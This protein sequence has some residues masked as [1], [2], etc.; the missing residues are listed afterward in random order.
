MEALDLFFMGVGF[1]TTKEFEDYDERAFGTWKVFQHV[2]SVSGS[3]ELVE[4][5]TELTTENCFAYI[6]QF[7]QLSE[8]AKL[9]TLQKDLRSNLRCVSKGDMKTL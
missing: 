6:K 9:M 4:V 3:G 1:A 2:M 7:Q 5:T 8:T